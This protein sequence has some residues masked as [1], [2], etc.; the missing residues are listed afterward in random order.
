MKTFLLIQKNEY[1]SIKYI[2]PDDEYAE[3]EARSEAISECIENDE[4]DFYFSL[5][6]IVHLDNPNTLKLLIEEN[7]NVLAPIMIKKG[8]V[9]SN[10][11]GDINQDG[12]YKRS[13]DYIDIIERNTMGIFNLPYIAEAVLTKKDILKKID[14]VSENMFYDASMTFAGL[15]RDKNIF[16]YGTNKEYFGHLIDTDNFDENL[17][18]PEMYEIM[19]NFDDWTDRYVHKQYIEFLR[20][21]S[22]ALEPCTDVYWFP[23]V[24]DEF[25]ED[26]IVMMETFGEW[27]GGRSNYGDDRL[28]GGVENVPTVDIHMKQIGWDKH[29]MVFLEKIMQ[30]MQQ[31]I[32][33]GYYNTPSA[34]LSFVVRYRPGEQDHLKPHNDAS[35]YTINIALNKPDIDFEGGG[36]RFLRRNCSVTKTKKGWAMMH[37]GRLTHF[38]EGLKVTKGTRYIMVTFIDP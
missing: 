19:N 17:I 6:P 25:C 3:F 9:W 11:W 23:L 30:P 34:L 4:C 15:L 27:S 13:I 28:P 33:P 16:M 22:K 8:S 12:F 20:N 1:H 21:S 7:K 35:T 2:S 29:W 37:P 36:C 18:R 31:V 26:L 24:N 5:S 32:F 38:H 10:I 14:F